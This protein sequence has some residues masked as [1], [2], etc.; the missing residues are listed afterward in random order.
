MYS[1][2][3]FFF[4]YKCD[5]KECT[6]TN[7][8]N[9][10]VYRFQVFTFHKLCDEDWE[11]PKIILK[12]LSSHLR[13]CSLRNFR[14]MKCGL[15]FAK[16]IMKNSRV[17]SVMTIQIPNFT[18]TNTKHRMVMELSPCPKCSTCKLLFI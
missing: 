7:L 5:R 11:E 13:I 10:T 18:D 17:L 15:H 6:H 1:K 3:F 2:S 8:I 12:C 4:V 16:Y 14:G 9:S